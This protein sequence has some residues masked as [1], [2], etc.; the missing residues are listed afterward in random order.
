MQ[1]TKTLPEQ[2]KESRLIPALREGICVVQMVLFKEVRTLLTGRYPHFQPPVIARLAGA[3]TNEIF[4]SVNEEPQFQEFRQ[5]HH[6]DIEQALLGL[7]RDLPALLPPLT[8]ALRMQVLCDQQENKESSRILIQ[9]A[10]I[11][12]L[13]ENRELPLPSS[14]I[15]LARTLGDRHGLIVP[16]IEI[17][18]ADTSQPL[19]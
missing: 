13:L 12:L 6:A 14:F 9:A 2:T 5:R 15:T 10:A 4:G 11:G 19:Q 16:P 3:I 8:D 17:T 18:P 7:G 1:N